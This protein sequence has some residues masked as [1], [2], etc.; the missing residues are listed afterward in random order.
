[1]QTTRKAI[2]Q[3]R[4]LL[5]EDKQKLEQEINNLMGVKDRGKKQ[6]R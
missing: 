1:V 6:N 5:H 3:I 2:K 4:S